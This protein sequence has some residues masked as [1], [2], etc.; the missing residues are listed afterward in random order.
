MLTISQINV[1]I[2]CILIILSFINSQTGVYLLSRN[3]DIQS[4]LIDGVPIIPAN[5]VITTDIIKK[6]S[7]ASFVPTGLITFNSIVEIIMSKAPKNSKEKSA[8]L[9][10]VAF[11]NES[12]EIEFSGTENEN[13]FCNID[14]CEAELNQAQI[15][16]IIDRYWVNDRYDSEEVNVS[17][18][19]R[20]RGRDKRISILAY[21]EENLNS[22]AIDN[23]SINIPTPNSLLK[24]DIKH[25]LNPGANIVI[26]ANES[27]SLL[28][29]AKG[30]GCV[31][32]FT[33]EDE[34]QMRKTI[35]TNSKEWKCD[36][37]TPSDGKLLSIPNDL[38]KVPVIWRDINYGTSTCIYK[39]QEL[40]Y[41][42]LSFE[43][44]TYSTGQIEVIEI[45]DAYKYLNPPQNSQ[46]INLNG[47]TVIKPG[48][49]IKIS[50][51]L[52]NT[53][54]TVLDYLQ[55]QIFLINDA[56]SRN[57][58]TTSTD[59][60][61]NGQKAYEVGISSSQLLT[62]FKKITPIFYKKSENTSSTSKTYFTCSYVI[63]NL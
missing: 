5:T 23:I 33:F 2:M 9:A 32:K 15:T 7:V 3:A 6:S 43:S 48:D 61:C 37:K 11:Q 51:F 35:I 8:L 58:I 1:K 25:F 20:E 38:S 59:W 63:V 41:S 49:I 60:E 45:G 62:D 53:Q 34:N 36:A 56:G 12:G 42:T 47:I 39:Y 31:A 10:S 17:F 19:I 44:I 28:G 52:N 46:Q 30:F 13:T 29:A 57:K 26:K 55:F 22:L 27:N 18:R 40:S 16:N 21:C 14:K 50:G 24:T 54:T 4:I